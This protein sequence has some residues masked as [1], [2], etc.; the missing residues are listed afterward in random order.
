VSIEHP[1]QRHQQAL[2]IAADHPVFPGHFPGAA[3]VPGVL[4]LSQVLEVAQQWL[5]AAV[6][7]IRLRQAKFP[8]PW[9]PG[10]P[11]QARLEYDGRQL[12]FDVS[13]NGQTL[14]QGVF[15]L[16]EHG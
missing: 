14:G 13:A 10:I 11:A 12:R 8:A 9:L 16:K 2:L 5:G 4:L 15:E 6:H 1:L 7:P 3:V